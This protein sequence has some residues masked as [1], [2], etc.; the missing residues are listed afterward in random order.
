[1]QKIVPIVEGDGEEKAVPNLIS[2]ILDHYG[3]SN[4]WYTGNTMRAGNL[5]HFKKYMLRYLKAAELAPGCS[6]I[7]LLF[8]LEDE[9]PKKESEII[10]Q[11]IKSLGIFCPVAL[12]F[13][14]REY[15]AWFLASLETICGNF[16]LPHNISCD[17]DI[18][19]IRDVKGWIS[20]QMPKK[21]QPKIYKETF[22]QAEMT[23]L[24]D[25]D[26]A[27]QRSRSFRR[28]IHAIEEIITSDP[29]TVTP[30]PR[31]PTGGPP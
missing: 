11:N 30:H 19:S 2:R 25:I 21:P 12:V 22:H 15:E 20:K 4:N 8:D 10:T 18:E 3:W 28:L 31:A 16:E 23:K 6:G 7:L 13:A 29:Y 14:H 17:R 27:S 1:M 24:I 26:I 5:G 9:C